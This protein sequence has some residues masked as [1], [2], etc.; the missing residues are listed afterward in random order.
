MKQPKPDD[1]DAQEQRVNVS[2]SGEQGAGWKMGQTDCRNWGFTLVSENSRLP[3]INRYRVVKQTRSFRIHV[4]NY[5]LQ[6]A[7]AF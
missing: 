4:D 5:G 7:D 3:L 6:M 1:D 2:R